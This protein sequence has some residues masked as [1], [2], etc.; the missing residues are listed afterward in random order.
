MAHSWHHAVASVKK[1]GG[2]EADYL[3]IHDFLDSTKAHMANVRHRAL[4]HNSWGIFLCEKLFGHVLTNSDGRVVQVRGVAEKHVQEDCGFIPSVQ[5]W[6]RHLVISESWMKT[7]GVK[8][9]HHQ[10]SNFGEVNEHSNHQDIN[11]DYGDCP[12]E[13]ADQAGSRSFDAEKVS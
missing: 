5:D 4:L 9:P 13:E 2:T 10:G 11:H 1:W 8:D 3:P 12:C 6:L 7:V